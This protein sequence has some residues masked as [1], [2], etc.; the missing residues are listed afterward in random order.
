VNNAPPCCHPLHTT[1]FQ[2]TLITEMIFMSHMAIKY[3]GHGLETSMRVRWKTCNVITGIIGR[4]FIEHQ[5]RI[6]ARTSPLPI[7]RRNLTPAPSEVLIAV[8]MR[9][10]VRKCGC[11]V[12]M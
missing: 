8:M 4:K 3:V 1:T 7:L 9:A 5:K 6:K 11:C 12:V 10:T 2:I